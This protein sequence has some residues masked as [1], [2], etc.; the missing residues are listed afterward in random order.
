MK[1]AIIMLSI[2]LL[3]IVTLSY[4]PVLGQTQKTVP[5]KTMFS[6]TNSSFIKDT[7]DSV[8]NETIPNY[9][10]LSNSEITQA[11][12]DLPGWIMM[13]E[14]LHKTF[15]FVD[16]STLFEFMYKV[17]EISQKLNHHPNMT[18]TWN[19]LALD[20]DT[21]SLG[22]VISNLDVRAAQNVEKTYQDGN[23]TDTEN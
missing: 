15:N 8:H 9:V 18:S 1:R 4:A 2:L 3:S 13:D 5:D 7:L 20:Y 23:Y 16:F 22:H 11:L 21:W 14:K 19:T 6:F 12:K 17:A 10:K